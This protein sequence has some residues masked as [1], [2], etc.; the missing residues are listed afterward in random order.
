[1]ESTNAYLNW[2]SAVNRV[3]DTKE[4]HERAQKLVEKSRLAAAA[5]M[6]PEVLVRNE[7]LASQAQ[8]RYVQAVF[9]ELL[10]LIALEKVCGGGI[11]PAFPGR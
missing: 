7:S 8:S 9:D 10:A 6:D 11:I 5:R 3:K 2:E 4:R 1:L